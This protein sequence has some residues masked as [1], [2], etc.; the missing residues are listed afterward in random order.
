MRTYAPHGG[1]AVARASGSLPGHNTLL[2]AGHTDK[3]SGGPRHQLP[4]VLHSKGA[5]SYSPGLPVPSAPRGLTSLFGM[6]R[7]GSPAPSP[8]C[9]FPSFPLSRLRAACAVAARLQE[10]EVRSRSFAESFRAIS[11]ARLCH[12]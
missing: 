12:R 9:L 1:K 10:T 7:G 8:P 6:G 11:T 4:A 5:V 2:K 3:K